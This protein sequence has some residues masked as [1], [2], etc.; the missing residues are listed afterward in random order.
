[1]S[2]LRIASMETRTQAGMH[3]SAHAYQLGYAR[4]SNYPNPKPS[5]SPESSC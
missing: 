4:L 2:T 1:M 3:V 5:F